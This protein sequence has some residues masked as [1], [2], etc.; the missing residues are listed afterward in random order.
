MESVFGGYTDIPWFNTKCLEKEKADL[1]VQ[2]ARQQAASLTAEDAEKRIK[3]ALADAEEANL[4]A[5]QAESAK[6]EAI[7]LAQE[8]K[9]KA[10]VNSAQEQEKPD[11]PTV[12]D[13]YSKRGH[14]TLTVW[15]FKLRG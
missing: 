11:A 12:A 3:E 7:T 15:Q 2:H 13:L 1:A 10:K 9:R 14:D 6:L 4:K 8:A 5:A